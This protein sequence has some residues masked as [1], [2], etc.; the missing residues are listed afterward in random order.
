MYSS[1][2][3][4]TQRLL[5]KGDSIPVYPPVLTPTSVLRHRGELCRADTEESRAFGRRASH[6]EDSA[7]RSDNQVNKDGFYMC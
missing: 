2:S 1:L 3:K 4:K 6:S 7:E 5:S